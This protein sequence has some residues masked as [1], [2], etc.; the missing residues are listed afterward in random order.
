M[1]GDPGCVRVL[2]FNYL[3]YKPCPVYY[4]VWCPPYQTIAQY[5]HVQTQ[6]ETIRQTQL[7]FNFPS[8]FQ[9]DDRHLFTEAQISPYSNVSVT[10]CDALHSSAR[11]DNANRGKYGRDIMLHRWLLT[12]GR[13]QPD[14]SRRLHLK[15][16][17]HLTHGHWLFVSYKFPQ[18]TGTQLIQESC[19][20]EQTPATQYGRPSK[21]SQNIPISL[22]RRFSN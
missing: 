1:L 8:D 22:C 3:D 2:T 20:T 7:P 6:M 5:Y 21:N 17:R 4:C 16:R 15:E 10:W 13:L 12:G 18:P 19:Q 9:L 14:R 11:T